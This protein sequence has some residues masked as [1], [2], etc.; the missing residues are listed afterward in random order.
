MIHNGASCRPTNARA[1]AC[2]MIVGVGGRCAHLPRGLTSR[3]PTLLEH[4]VADA[5]IVSEVVHHDGQHLSAYLRHGPL[6]DP[7]LSSHN[8]RRSRT[9]LGCSPIWSPA[10]AGKFA[11]RTFPISDLPYPRRSA[12]NAH[13]MVALGACLPA[14]AD[15]AYR[16][17]C[18]T[19]CEYAALEER[20]IVHANMEGE[21]AMQQRERSGAAVGWTAFAAI[22]MV[23]IGIWWIFAGL[24]GLINHTFYATT[25][26]YIFKFSPTSWGWI[27]LIT[28]IVVLLAGF[29][30]FTGAIWARTVGVIMAVWAMLVGFAW[31]PWYPIWAIIIITASFFVMWALTAHGRDIAMEE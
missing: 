10:F 20:L 16:C 22:T 9:H 19:E 12:R 3:S 8:A 23:L 2:G 28:G 7:A 26:N 6:D 1:A 30:L 13:I 17:I 24:I 29:A 21:A 15:Y 14:A 18:A 31:L 5:R 25:R 27:H 4:H 11:K